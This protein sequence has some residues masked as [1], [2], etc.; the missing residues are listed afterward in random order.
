MMRRSRKR[1]GEEEEGEAA[2]S[3]PLY[4]LLWLQTLLAACFSTIAVSVAIPSDLEWICS[5][6]LLSL[7]LPS[8]DL[9]KFCFPPVHGLVGSWQGSGSL[10]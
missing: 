9:Y 5:I 2:S 6:C 3:V 10:R 4:W 1:K 8:P 7:P